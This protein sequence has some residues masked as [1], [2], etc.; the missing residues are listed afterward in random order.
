MKPDDSNPCRFPLPSPIFVH[1]NA[2]YPSR[3]G[4]GRGLCR[5]ARA[6]PDYNVLSVREMCC[7]AEASEGAGPSLPEVL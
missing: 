1:A 6:G 5:T 2:G 4:G 3:C 7:G